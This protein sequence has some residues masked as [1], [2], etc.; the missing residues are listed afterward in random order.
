M[1][2][3]RWL[4]LFL[5]SLLLFIYLGSRFAFR[6]RANNISINLKLKLQGVFQPETQLKLRLD[7][8]TQSGRAAQFQ[9]LILKA[10]NNNYFTGVV[11][12]EHN[13][14]LSVPYALFI[15][16][17]NYLGRL[18]CSET[19]SG[20]ECQYPE[21]ILSNSLNQ[22][23]LSQKPFFSGDL[24]PQDGKVDSGDLSRLFKDIGN[25]N[26]PVDINLDGIVNGVDYALAQKTLSLNLKDDPI[27]LV[28]MTP[29]L[30]PTPT[31]TI[32][33]ITEP[34]NNPTP[35]PTATPTPTPQPTNTPTP[36]PQ[37]TRG[38]CNGNITGQVR[39]TYFGITE[40][41]V[42]NESDYRCVD[43]AS[44]C[45]PSFCVD[46]TKEAIRTSVKQCS[47]G[48]ASF[49][50]ANSPI[51]CQVNFVPDASCQD[52]AP[53]TSCNDTRPKCP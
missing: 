5:I 38:R 12:L 7:L 36:A 34:T 25:T 1:K 29:T 40:C 53:N 15:K 31:I 27:N 37:A 9:N 47:G 33:T 10:D 30:V 8:Y 28:E 2:K 18:F 52:P 42:L 51:S 20:Q 14:D 6:T 17:E 24:V 35:L 41:R 48:I 3:S 4:W 43:S 32:P 23:D 19:K 49:D 11:I 21:I 39:I 26:S 13:L 22:L 46:F 16:P 44:E 50:E 45:T